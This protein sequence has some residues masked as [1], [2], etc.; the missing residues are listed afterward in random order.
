MVCPGI[1]FHHK[2]CQSPCLFLVAEYIILLKICTLGNSHSYS[3]P[4]L[5]A[6]QCQLA[7]YM[8]KNKARFHA[9]NWQRLSQLEYLLRRWSM[10]LRAAH[11]AAGDNKMHARLLGVNNFF[12]ETQTDSLN[13]FPLLSY[14]RNSGLV[15]KLSGYPTSEQ[16]PKESAK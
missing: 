9:N 13:L 6:A 4:R 7:H 8:T 5:S 10:C 3:Y 2:C 16:P 1:I 14:L 12:F 15:R 11:K